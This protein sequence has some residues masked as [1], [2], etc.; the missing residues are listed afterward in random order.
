MIFILFF[1]FFSFCTSEK[2]YILLSFLKDIFIGLENSRLTEF[3]S[4]I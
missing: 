1:N 3:L 2:L 4:V